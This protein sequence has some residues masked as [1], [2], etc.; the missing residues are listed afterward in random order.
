MKTPRRIEGVF[1][2]PYVVRFTLANG[3][4]RKLIRWSPGVPWVYSEVARELVDRYG[5]EGIK[6]NS[7]TIR[8]RIDP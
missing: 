4:R 3:K 6:P 8:P 2:W 5:L 1:Y 7:A